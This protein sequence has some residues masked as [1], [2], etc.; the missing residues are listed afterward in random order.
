MELPAAITALSRLTELRLGQSVSQ[1][2]PLQLRRK[3]PLD[4]RALGDLSGLPALCEL[5]FDWCE[6]MLCGSLLG[7]VR[8]ARLASLFFCNSHPAPECVPVVLQLSQA[9][10]RQRRGSVLKV[11]GTGFEGTWFTL[12]L[13]Y[14][15]GWAPHQKFK[16]ALEAC[17]P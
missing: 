2:D 11:D 10:R 16:A 3:R 9:L 17:R 15:Q 7:A 1:I 4:V 5:R 14:A 13:K 6:V 12:A 8:H